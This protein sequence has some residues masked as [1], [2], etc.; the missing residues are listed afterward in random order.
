[1]LDSHDTWHH[2]TVLQCNYPKQATLHVMWGQQ[3]NAESENFARLAGGVW[4]GV[5]ALTACEASARNG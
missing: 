3:W 4:E 1:M 5:V 2:G